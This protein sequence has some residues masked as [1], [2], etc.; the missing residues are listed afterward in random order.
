M[1]IRNIDKNNDWRFG[2]SQSDYVRNAYAVA[3]D[4]K[5]SLQE[6]F[7][8]C[9]FALQKGIP[10]SI[11]L[12]SKNQKQVLEND[13]LTIAQNVEGVLNIA[14]FQSQVYGRRYRCSFKVYQMYSTETLDIDFDSE[15]GVIYNAG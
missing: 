10:W 12:G 8:D 9:F 7:G 1:R 5:M 4:I 13:I 14:D 15:K 6:W 3:I 11:R 2:K